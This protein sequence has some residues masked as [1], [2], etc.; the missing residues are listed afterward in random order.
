MSA[1]LIDLGA[2]DVIITGTFGSYTIRNYGESGTA[3]DL[4]SIDDNLYQEN[5]GAFGDMLVNKSYKAQNMLLTLTTLRKSTDYSRLRAIVAEELSGGPV[6]MSVLVRDNNG[7]ESYFSAQ[8][9]MKNNPS[10]QAGSQPDANVEFK[11]LMP[12]TVATAPEL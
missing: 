2:V 5:V 9:Y 1:H 11:I 8:A 12:S 6:P 4:S 10:F 3:I 7:G